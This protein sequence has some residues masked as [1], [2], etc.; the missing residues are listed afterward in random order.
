MLNSKSDIMRKGSLF[1]V[2]SEEDKK[3]SINDINREYI[4]KK[5]YIGESLN[6]Y[7]QLNILITTVFS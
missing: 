3:K 2:Y 1:R 5:V 4:Y 7:M 6:M